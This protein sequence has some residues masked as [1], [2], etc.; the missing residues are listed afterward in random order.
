MTDYIVESEE[1][2]R[3]WGRGERERGEGLSREQRRR[4]ALETVLD[5]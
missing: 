4:F 1:R 3:E 5:R 2:E